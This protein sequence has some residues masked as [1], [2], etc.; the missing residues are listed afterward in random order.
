M[1]SQLQSIR[2]NIASSA[3]FIGPTTSTR[4]CAQV[5]EGCLRDADSEAE[6]RRQGGKGRATRCR[7]GKVVA[8]LLL[9]GLDFD[10]QD[11][12]SGFMMKLTGN[13]AEEAVRETALTDLIAC[14][15]ANEFGRN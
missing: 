10:R 12:L 2:Q 13:F 4:T 9:L 3:R 8:C 1:K 5:R 6:A 7:E 11:H 15:S 14:A